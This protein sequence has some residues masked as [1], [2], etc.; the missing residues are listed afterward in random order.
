MENNDEIIV[1]HSTK[2]SELQPN[3]DEN[4]LI[5]A[6]WNDET[7]YST[8]LLANYLRAVK[9]TSTRLPDSVLNE[10][11]KMTDDEYKSNFLINEDNVNSILEKLLKLL[12]KN[13]YKL[14]ERLFV[15]FLQ[16][17]HT[18]NKLSLN[19]DKIKLLYK[20]LWKALDMKKGSAN[21]LKSL[22]VLDFA[23]V[24]QKLERISFEA[25][26]DGWNIIKY[27]DGYDEVLQYCI[28]DLSGTIRAKEFI[29]KVS[30]Q[31]AKNLIDDVRNG[32][33]MIQFCDLFPEKLK[34][35]TKIFEEGKEKS[36]YEIIL[37]ELMKTN[38][39][40]FLMIVLGKSSISS[41]ISM[42]SGSTGSSLIN[43]GSRIPSVGS[44]DPKSSS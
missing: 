5:E 13:D 29:D 6:A 9:E 31:L 19:S 23:H 33:S 27:I 35:Y 24:R 18:S 28:Q 36:N 8:K 16:K 22:I 12:E 1:I 4:A 3:E 15:T 7:D 14:D 32:L 30:G 34:F 42:S 38:E 21:L 25:D 40:D 11:S 37:N 44:V 43:S 20:H 17:I 10:F 41:L 26:R 2:S 39:N